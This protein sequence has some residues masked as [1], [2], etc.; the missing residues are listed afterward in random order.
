MKRDH[1]KEVIQQLLLI[2][3]EHGHPGLVL[4]YC[5]DERNRGSKDIDAIAGSFAI[6]HTSI[7]GMPQQRGH[8]DRFLKLVRGLREELKPSLGFQ[9]NV[10]L[11]YDDLLA[12][13]G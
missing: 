12:A 10:T 5:P 13:C 11:S 7:D 9:A 3:G 2:L 8:D 4:R 1:E 6:E